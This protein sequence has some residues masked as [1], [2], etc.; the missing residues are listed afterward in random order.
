MYG[1]VRTVVWQGSAGDRRPYA[2]Q[3][4][5]WEVSGPL[6][7]ELVLGGPYRAD[8]SL[9]NW[10]SNRMLFPDVVGS[11]RLLDSMMVHGVLFLAKNNSEGES[12]AN[13]FS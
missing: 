8:K 4:G 3:V 13:S 5:L 1:P 10:C 6:N 11:W 12:P 9:A 2:D 7:L